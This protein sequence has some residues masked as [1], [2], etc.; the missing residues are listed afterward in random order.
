MKQNFSMGLY[1]ATAAPFQ[2]WWAK[3][4]IY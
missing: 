3:T 1:S 4:L 2:F